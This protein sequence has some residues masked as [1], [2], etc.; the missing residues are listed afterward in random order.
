MSM[1]RLYWQVS[2]TSIVTTSSFNPVVAINMFC[3]FNLWLYLLDISNVT[4]NRLH[5]RM[6]NNIGCMIE[7]TGSQ[8]R[9]RSS[10]LQLWSALNR[11]GVVGAGKSELKEGVKSKYSDGHYDTRDHTKELEDT[12]IHL[13]GSLQGTVRKLEDVD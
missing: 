5:E 7:L 9:P 3:H 10:Q 13:C 4:S 11:S 12:R 6:Y 8:S 1:E 2:L